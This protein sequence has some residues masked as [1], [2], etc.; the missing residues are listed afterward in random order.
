M[1]DKN[2]YIADFPAPG[3]PPPLPPRELVIPSSPPPSYSLLPSA[4]DSY[5]GSYSQGDYDPAIQ[6]PAPLKSPPDSIPRGKRKLLLVYIHGF[7]GNETSFQSFP[8]HLH[9]LLSITLEDLGW[10]VHTKVYPKFKTRYNISVATEG[11][12][13]WLAQF[14]NPDTDVI[15]LGHSMGGILAAEVVLLRNERRGFR[16]RI[17]GVVSFDSPFIGMHPGVISAGLGS[18]FRSEGKSPVEEDGSGSAGG[19]Y[20]GENSSMASLST[21]HSGSTADEFFDR[22]PER[23]FTIVQSKQ[24]KC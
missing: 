23:N 17:L 8:A 14:E 7:M 5:S 6:T 20:A 9:N 4:E 12:S 3:V 15:L 10:Y 16:H 21:V 19:V 24:G 1:A 22:R 13:K 2:N 11:F 18:L